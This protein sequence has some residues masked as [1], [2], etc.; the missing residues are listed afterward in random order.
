[1]CW[2]SPLTVPFQL[3]HRCILDAMMAICGV[4]DVKFRTVCSTIDKL[5]KSPWSEVR[6]E[7][8]SEKGL[9]PAVADRIGR[10]IVR[11]SLCS[12]HIT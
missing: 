4:P 3:N 2:A 6:D 7:M 5:D 9:D 11:C 1:M 12:T 8:V 10:R